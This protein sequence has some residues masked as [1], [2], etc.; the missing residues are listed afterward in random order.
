MRTLNSLPFGPTTAEQNTAMND[1]AFRYKP[2]VLC[3]ACNEILTLSL[4]LHQLRGVQLSEYIKTTYNFGRLCGSAKLGCHV[5]ALFE[6]SLW[7]RPQDFGDSRMWN[8]T[9]AFTLLPATDPNAILMITIECSGANSLCGHGLPLYSNDRAAAFDQGLPV[10][11]RKLSLGKCTGDVDTFDVAKTWFDLCLKEHSLCAQIDVEFRAVRPRRMLHL[12][13]TIRLVESAAAAGQDYVSLSHC[14]GRQTYVPRLLH[15]TEAMLREGVGLSYLPKTFQEAVI[16]TRR[17]GFHFL[18]IDSLCILQDSDEDWR[19]QAKIMAL[20]Y[21]NSVLTIAALKSAGSNEG[22][23]TD[24]RNPLCL[25]PCIRDDLGLAVA[26]WSPGRLWEVEVNTSGYGA[27]PLHSRA[28]VVQERYS[29]P[30]TLLYGTNGI[31]WECRC[32]QASESHYRGVA[33]DEEGNKKTWLQRLKIG[34]YQTDR[35]TKQ[36]RTVISWR[37]HWTGLLDTY[38]SCEVTVKTDKIIAIMGLISKIERLSEARPRCML[39]LW[40]YDLPGMAL[41]YRVRDDLNSPTDVVSRL[42]NGM[43][44]W[45]WASVGGR[46]SYLPSPGEIEWQA[47]VSIEETASSAAP[48]AMRIKAWRRKVLIDEDD[49]ILLDPND[50]NTGQKGWGG[51]LDET[52]SLF[53]DCEVPDPEEA[54]FVVPMQRACISET[55]ELWVARCIVVT[56][57]SKDESEFRRVGVVLIRYSNKKDD[58]FNFNHPGAQETIIMK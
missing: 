33:W 2:N 17:L 31:Y 35:D 32:A 39:G 47:T 23:F 40:D 44:T 38:S 3:P 12:D 37:D 43:P 10:P 6:S 29:S 21:A 50:P 11:A 1:I 58:P 34:Q 27:S 28:W 42:D 22:C 48:A 26:L 56:P 9:V 36:K 52:Y 20:V 57:S 5:C 19:D 18:W 49:A 41:W 55:T 4:E 53:P 7:T 25:R 13:N 51:D 8:W 24:N 30:R 46:C 14:W 16:V 15:T 45:S 54:L